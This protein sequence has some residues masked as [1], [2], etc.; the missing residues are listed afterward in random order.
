MSANT[1]I[2]TLN[3]LVSEVKEDWDK[4]E[5]HKY[6]LID[7]QTFVFPCIFM[8]LG[9]KLT[10]DQIEQMLSILTQEQLD[11]INKKLDDKISWY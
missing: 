3:R 10:F 7:A 2:S 1:Y 11:L 6:E 8:D 9:V 4:Y 5:H